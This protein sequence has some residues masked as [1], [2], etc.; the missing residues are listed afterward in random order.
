MCRARLNDMHV[1]RLFI[2]ELGKKD[3]CVAI[4]RTIMRPGLSLGMITTAEG[5]EAEGQ[6]EI[7]CR[8]AACRSRAICSASRSRH[9]RSR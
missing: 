7:L 4:I 9:G 3:D 1:S 6:L 2:R 8:E 5:V